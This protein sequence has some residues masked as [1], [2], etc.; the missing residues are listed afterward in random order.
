MQTMIF[1]PCKLGSFTHAQSGLFPGSQ[2]KK[3][4]YLLAVIINNI[5][6]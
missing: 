1:Y 5:K 4:S 3:L 6:D 2:G